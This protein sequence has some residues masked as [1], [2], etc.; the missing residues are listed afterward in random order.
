MMKKIFLLSF[1]LMGMAAMAAPADTSQ[2]RFRMH[3]FVNPVLFADSRQVVSGREGMMLFFPAAPAFDA[4]GVDLNGIPLLNMLAIT[5]RLNLTIEG[6]DVLGAKMRGF[7]EGDFTGATDPTINMFRLRHAYLDMSWQHHSILAG[8]YWHPMVIHEI[9]PMTQPLNMGAPFHPYARYN[10]FRYR[11]HTGCFEA[12]AVAAFQLDNKSQ[13]PNGGSTSYLRNAMVPEMNVQLRYNGQNVMVGV[14]ANYRRLLPHTSYVAD[15][16]GNVR[17]CRTTYDHI[18]YSVFGRLRMGGWTLKAQTLLSD[19]LY[20]ICSVGGYLSQYVAPSNAGEG[21]YNY[22]PWTYTTVWA[23]LGRNKGHWR[24][25]IFMGYGRNNDFGLSVENNTEVYGRG[26]NIE[27]LYRVQPRIEYF[28]GNGL[29]L[30][31]ELEHTFAQYGQ[32]VTDGT[33]GYHYEATPDMAVANTRGIFGIT[34][35]F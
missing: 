10:Q 20:E 22:A 5:A 19:D 1:L 26:F 29:T 13:G 12:L 28:A 11:F 25:G 24:P 2:W 23:D 7:I 14:A 30:S 15:L 34:Y 33:T 8:Q 32:R 18:S 6:P 3:G 16:L 9:M 21:H 27:Y 17:Q 35:A 31:L 4:D